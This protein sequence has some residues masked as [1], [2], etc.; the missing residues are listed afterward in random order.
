MKKPLH[1]TKVLSQGSTLAYVKDRVDLESSYLVDL[2]FL[3]TI[4]EKDYYHYK[5]ADKDL[6]HELRTKTQKL[7]WKMEG[8]K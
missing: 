4:L 6:C 7:I 5:G 1:D 3:F 8:G 2:K